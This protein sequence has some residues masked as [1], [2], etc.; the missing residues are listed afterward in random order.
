MVFLVLAVAIA[1][2]I[3]AF[4]VG[5]GR[6]QVRWLHEEG[7]HELARALSAF[8]AT[9]WA[10]TFIVIVRA[11]LGERMIRVVGFVVIGIALLIQF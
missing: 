8:Q 1:I 6:L 9:P 5:V 4:K 7:K 3:T 10:G 2:W 11:V